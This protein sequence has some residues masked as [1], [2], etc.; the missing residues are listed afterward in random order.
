MSFAGAVQAMITT[1][2]NNARD[3]RTLYDRKEIFSRK[4]SVQ[5]KLT[6]DRKATPEQLSVI[7]ER[8][9]KYNRTV[10]LRSSLVFAGVLL[11]L[12]AVAWLVWPWLA[13]W[14]G[15]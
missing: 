3:R 5:R 6:E 8:L 1:L 12:F 9:H 4:T 10:V 14:L 13:G 7:R 15:F 11:I 2:K